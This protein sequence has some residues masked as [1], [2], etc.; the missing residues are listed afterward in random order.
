MGLSY[1]RR[2]VGSLMVNLLGWTF[3]AEGRNCE[4][5]KDSPR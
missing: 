4:A 3:M 5:V 2:R 1:L